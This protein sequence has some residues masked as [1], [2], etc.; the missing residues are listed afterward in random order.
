MK[1]SKMPS[2]L[3]LYC[4]VVMIA[5]LNAARSDDTK[6]NNATADAIIW[7]KKIHDQQTLIL[8][9][10]Q[11]PRDAEVKKSIHDYPGQVRIPDHVYLYTLKLLAPH[12]QKAKLLWTKTLWSYE[13]GR[14]PSRFQVL[15]ADY[16]KNILIFVYNQSGLILAEVKGTPDSKGDITGP[17]SSPQALLFREGQAGPG[18]ENIATGTI[19]GSMQNNTLTVTL[20]NVKG[21][22]GRYSWGDGSILGTAKWVPQPGNTFVVPQ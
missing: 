2:F 8:F 19:N 21:V 18:T 15:D 3:A 11:L 16:Q 7:Q 6:S 4:F 12:S 1:L 9:Q 20:K 17:N 5:A 14:F 22:M 13:K 10:H